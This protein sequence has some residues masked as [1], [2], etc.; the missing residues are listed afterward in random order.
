MASARSTVLFV[1]ESPPKDAPPNFRPFDCAS[2]DRLA[3]YATGLSS[4]TVLLE[5]V[6]RDNI[7]ATPGVGI[8]PDFAWDEAAARDAGEG[9]VARYSPRIKTFVALG[10]K[11]AAALGHAGLEFSTWAVAPDTRAHVVAVP[12]P[13]GGSTS[14][15]SE[16]KRSQV[17]RALIPE[18]VA[19]CPTLRPWH[20]RTDVAIALD[21]GAAVSPGDPVLGVATC[22][23]VALAWSRP[24]RRA[25]DA[26]LVEYAEA[27]SLRDLA[28][29]CALGDGAV[30]D[31]LEIARGKVRS[32]VGAIGK[33]MAGPLADYPVDARR[34]TV[35]RYVCLGVL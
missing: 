27:L 7:F 2:G 30:A 28:R 9:L 15:N 34:A 24:M 4:R 17:R 12:H 25:D 16:L 19:G 29:L 6:E 20:F 3:K 32:A 26:R 21:L 10:R 31:A 33:S 1:G 35:G 14:L 11:P 5:H 22:T 13:S 18:L 23:L 8:A